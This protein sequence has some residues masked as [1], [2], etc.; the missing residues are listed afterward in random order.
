VRP[1][2]TLTLGKRLEDSTV[3]IRDHRS[4]ETA[5]FDAVFSRYAGQR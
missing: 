2:F 4:N 5:P 3:V 1:A